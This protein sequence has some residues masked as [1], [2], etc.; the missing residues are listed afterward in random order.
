MQSTAESTD[1]CVYSEWAFTYRNTHL[2]H[3]KKHHC[4]YDFLFNLFGF[5]CFAYIEWTTD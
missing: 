1:R 3:V 4:T 5:S 2:P